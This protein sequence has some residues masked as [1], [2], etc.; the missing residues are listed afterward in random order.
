M[1]LARTGASPAAAAP[2]ELRIRT[3]GT[4]QVWLGEVPLTFRRRKSL[5]L[6]VY[7]ALTGRAHGREVLASL[8]VDRA[9]DAQAREQF[10][11]TLNGLVEQVGTF[12]LVTRETIALDRAQPSRLDADELQAATLGPSEGAAA[13]DP[14]RLERAVALYEGAFLSGFALH[15][16]PLFE[17]WMRE[18]RARLDRLHVQALQLL[19][20]RAREGRDE[21]AALRWT[22]P[23][24]AAW[25]CLRLLARR[26][27]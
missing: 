3:L 7:L 12:L 17:D 10:R 18:Q 24:L 2:A 26:G 25:R 13:A 6:L 8:F 19:L 14:R 21:E 11:T 4:P 1:S 23:L 20:E 27:Q 16:A 22:T 9:S 5:A 15:D